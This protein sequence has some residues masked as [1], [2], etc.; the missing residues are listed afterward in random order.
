[1]NLSFFNNGKIRK[2]LFLIIVLSFVIKVGVAQTNHICKYH[3]LY[4]EETQRT[5]FEKQES[6]CFNKVVENQNDDFNKSLADSFKSSGN[7]SPFLAYSERD[8]FYKVL[9]KLFLDMGLSA[10]FVYTHCTFINNAFA[11]N[12]SNPDGGLDR[13]IVVDKYFLKKLRTDSNSDYP[14]LSILLHEAG[15]HLNNHTFTTDKLSNFDRELQADEFSGFA[16][17]KLGA[18][19]EDALYA[20]NEYGSESD[21][22]SHPNKYKRINAIKKGWMNCNKTNKDYSNYSYA[23]LIKIS[24]GNL[25]YMDE[26]SVREN[27]KKSSPLLGKN[28]YLPWYLKASSYYIKHLYTNSNRELLEL[29]R[30]NTINK[31][32]FDKSDIYNL[33]GSNYKNMGQL[34]EAV[35]YYNKTINLYGNSNKSNIAEA[36]IDRAEIAL[37]LEQISLDAYKYV[38][39]RYI[40]DIN[41]KEL[42]EAKI[43]ISNSNIKV[44]E[45]RYKLYTD[46]I[47]K[48]KTVIDFSNLS[49]D[50][51]TL[52]I[53]NLITT[54]RYDEA[55]SYIDKIDFDEF[56]NGQVW[57]FI[58][59][60]INSLCAL[61]RYDEAKAL[62]IEYKYN[63][64][65]PNIKYAIENGIYFY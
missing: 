57:T 27:M 28:G 7:F 1:M 33:I 10:N 31:W 3:N 46:Y 59:L 62:N 41:Y 64:C 36:F 25:I 34:G 61:K 26:L 14:A 54:A 8:E 15:H 16:L 58:G 65:N 32:E 5:F 44:A 48:L 29:L 22:Y 53:T 2:D 40:D 17:C 18:T 4:K 42:R 23:E 45:A 52:L 55:I 20:I 21:S 60:K 37:D 35:E 39:A 6:I 19:I 43:S 63:F 50:N 9:E 12:I 11:S 24:N 13:Y 47:N 49:V 38:I 51:K 56:T 30:L